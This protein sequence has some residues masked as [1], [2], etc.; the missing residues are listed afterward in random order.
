M[1]FEWDG[2]KAEANWRKHRIEFELATQ[3]FFDPNRIEKYDASHYDGE[4]RWQTIGMAAPLVLMV[5]YTERGATGE[6]VRLIS[7][8]KANK[9]ERE[10]YRKNFPRPE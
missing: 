4:E 8:R 6:I 10:T 2:D 1:D 3:V 7:A 5:V 9:Y